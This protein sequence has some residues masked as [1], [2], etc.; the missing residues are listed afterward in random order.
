MIV[1]SSAI[2]AVLFQEA[3]SPQ[4]DSL[5]AGNVC[6]MSVANAVESAIVLERWGARQLQMN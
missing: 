4:F 6:Q 2:L 3:D 1:D 5:I